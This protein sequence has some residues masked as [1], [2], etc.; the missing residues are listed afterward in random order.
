[1]IIGKTLGDAIATW[2]CKGGQNNSN[3]FQSSLIMLEEL[4][5]IKSK[6]LERKK[7]LSKVANEVMIGK[8]YNNSSVLIKNLL[9]LEL[10]SFVIEII[11]KYK[12]ELPFRNNDEF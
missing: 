7:L 12:S 4:S 3:P 6:N 2:N 5:N 1:M 8:S 10:Q 11:T 9:P